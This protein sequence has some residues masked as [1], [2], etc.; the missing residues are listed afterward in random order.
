MRQ[1]NN[2]L[3]RDVGDHVTRLL[4]DQLSETIVFHNLD[5]AR[6]VVDN[7]AYVGKKSNLND[8]E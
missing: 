4:V 3:V 7:A 1:I 8:E 6:Y 5:H 2:E